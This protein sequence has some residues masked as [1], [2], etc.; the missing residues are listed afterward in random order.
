[1]A[2]AGTEEAESANSTQGAE[3]ESD[4]IL[5]PV[6]PEPETPPPPPAPEDPAQPIVFE[7]WKWYDATVACTTATCPN[8]NVVL[9]L[10]EVYSNAGQVT[11][12]CGVCSKRQKLLSATLMDPQPPEE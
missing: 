1:M 11:F 3:A 2:E 8:L 9:H 10:T 12:Y 6:E 4:P 5:D 7:P